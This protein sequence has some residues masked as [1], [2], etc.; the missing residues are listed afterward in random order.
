[1]EYKYIKTPEQLLL[2]MNENI[3][4]GFVDSKGKKYGPWNNEEFQY[5]NRIKWKLS[6]PKRLLKVKF[7][8]CYDQVELERDWLTKNGYCCKTF[9]IWFELPFINSY[10]THTYLIYE[11]DGKYYYFEHSD[12]N[13]RGIYSFDSI[14]DAINYQKNLYIES[15]KKRNHI[16][17]EIL[18]HLHI[19][20]YDKPKYGCNMNEF[21]NSILNNA[22]EVEIVNKKK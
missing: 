17:D 3:K 8:H 20:E 13:N 22:K 18:Q 4:Y 14:E 11:N 9:Y 21:I 6:S 12:F 15:N 2:Y 16:D 5:N 19:Y 1:M 10:S 7:G